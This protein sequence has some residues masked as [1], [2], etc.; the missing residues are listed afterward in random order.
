MPSAAATSESESGSDAALARYAASMRRPRAVY[1]A[2]LAVIVLA[3][4]VVAVVAYEH[5]EIAHT[6]LHTAASAPPALTDTRPAATETSLWH[7]GDHTAIGAPQWGGTVVVYGGHTVRGLDART[8]RQ[9]WAYTRTDRTV[10]AAVQTAG[11]TVAFYEVHGNCDEVTALRSGTGKRRWT[12]TLDFNGQP[13]NGHP[14]YQVLSYTVMV[15][16]P[17]VIY[18]LDPGSGYN[19]WIFGR[20][21]CT[22][23]GAVLGTAGALISQ[24]CTNPRCQTEKYCARGPQLLLRD[25]V[26]GRDDNSKV[27]PDRIHWNLVGNTDFPVSADDVIG[28][29][30]P[31]TRALDA[32]RADKGRPASTV[33]L[34]PAPGDTTVSTATTL[35]GPELL[36]LGGVTYVVRAGADRADWAYPSDGPPTAVPAGRSGVLS[37]STALLTVT[38]A[39][40][41][42]VLDVQSGRITATATLTPAP[43]RGSIAYPLGSGLLVAAG[44]G[45]TAYR[46]TR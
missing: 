40:G 38:T 27:N 30:N 13:L 22:I 17:S 32:Y 33:A 31:T 43:P 1:A 35:A 7:T 3:L 25:G 36:W 39:Q 9:T 28:A 41:A 46:A 42:R 16:T 29:L 14:S 10:C 4:G 18:A 20:Y 5:G 24:N 37:E 19:R 34:V 2:V 6:T 15:T 11:T 44:S 26:N 21:G 12:R 8:G 45:T 23:R